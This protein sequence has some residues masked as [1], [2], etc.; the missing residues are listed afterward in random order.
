MFSSSITLHTTITIWSWDTLQAI[1]PELTASEKRSLRRYLYKNSDKLQPIQVGNYVFS[2]TY[3]PE[4]IISQF[5]SWPTQSYHNV[6]ILEGRSIY[7]IDKILSNKWYFD[8]G[9]YIE[10]VS[11]PDN[12]RSIRNKYQF[13]AEFLDSQPQSS[14]I[15][16]SLEW[17]L[18]PDTYHID[19]NQRFLDQLVSL[20]LKNFN[21]KVYTPYQDLIKNF[22]NKL[23]GAWYSYTLW[24]YNIV[25]L[26]SI[27]E[28]EERN[29]TNKATIAGIFLNRINTNMQLGADITLCYGLQ[30][31]YEYCTP[32]YIVASIRDAN[33]LYN[34]RV[35]HWLT[36][37]PITN[38]ASTSF[39]AVLNFVK[40]DYY[41]YL[42]GSDG[43]IHYWKTLEQ[44]NS[45]KRYL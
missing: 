24:R 41:Y 11:N 3:M 38:P 12:I 35:H 14:N 17:L 18:Y 8:E 4:D 21:R 22:S 32:D 28:K 39:D 23:S 13:V 20:Q 29:N 2:G 33:N 26:A 16:P 45:N 34:T 5:N 36:P 9:E 42:H 25:T 6:K 7:D 30:R 43:Q 1:Y 15:T 37:G 10:Y 19:I 40:T 31:G 27:I 44:H